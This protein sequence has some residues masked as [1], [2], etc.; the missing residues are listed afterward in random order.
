MAYFKHICVEGYKRLRQVDLEMRDLAFLIGENGVGKTSFLEVWTLLAAMCEGRLS[1]RLS[2]LSGVSEIVTRDTNDAITIELAMPIDNYE[3]I[4][5]RIQI[6]PQ[7]QNYRIVSESLSQQRTGYEEPFFHITAKGHQVQYYD[8]NGLVHPTWEHN[9]NETAL[10]QVP[11]MFKQSEDFR[12][13]LAS[14]T[15]YGPLDVSSKGP[16]R[17]PQ[18]LRPA[19]LPGANGE[20][21]ISCLYQLRETDHER[22]ERITDTLSAAF[23]D[24]ERLDFPPVAAGMLSMTWKDRNFAHPMYM[25]Q[26]SE[27]TLRFLWL[28]TL[29][30]SSSLPTITLIDEPEVSLHPELLR[31][32]VELMREASI[33]T[34]LIVATHS[35]RLVGFS[36]PSEVL[37]ADINENG[38]ASFT[39]ADKMDIEKWLEDYSLDQLWQMNLLGGRP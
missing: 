13:R 21:L 22:Y 8:G 1:R 18:Q 14:V 25:H 38:V 7:A 5:Y 28:A 9:E 2:D 37:V 6:E 23:S 10:S 4:D 33:R 27:G 11:K 31:L 17:L 30:Q 16:I 19:S 20:D 34:Q 12:H 29:L 32:L 35:D 39:W 26:L 3:P 36:E 24:F 15:Y